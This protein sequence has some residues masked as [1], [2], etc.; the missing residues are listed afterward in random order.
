MFE[1]DEID[2]EVF[3][4]A[5]ETHY[6]WLRAQETIVQLTDNEIALLK[7]RVAAMKDEEI[8]NRKSGN[9]VTM[10]LHI[11]LNRERHQE[12][13][14]RI[15]DILEK[16]PAILMEPHAIDRLLSD[17]EFRGWED[18]EDVIDCVTSARF[19][20]G[21]R[22]TVNPRHPKNTEKVKY[23]HTNFAIEIKGKKKNGDG[24]LVLVI[25]NENRISVVTI[26]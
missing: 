1:E 5:E 7:F 13:M 16:D 20:N 6:K 12:I 17:G 9:G 15:S 24:R 2:C 19:V 25:F 26:L 11:K 23:L 4:S 10:G 3:I 18:E 14:K 22:L 8:Q 21:V